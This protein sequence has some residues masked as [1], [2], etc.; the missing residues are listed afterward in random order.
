MNKQP[1]IENLEDAAAYAEL[2]RQ[3]P[4]HNESDDPDLVAAFRDAEKIAEIMEE[5]NDSKQTP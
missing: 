2:M 5:A 1:K 3:L 4:V